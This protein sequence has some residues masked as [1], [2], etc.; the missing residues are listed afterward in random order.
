MSVASLV[1]AVVVSQNYQGYPVAPRTTGMGGAATALGRGVGNS[2]YNP[3]SIAWGDKELVGDVSGNLFAGSLTSLSSQFGL[4]TEAPRFSVQIIPSNLSLE[5]R[6]LK[7]GP[8]SLSDRWGLGVSVVAPFD[9]VLGSLVSSPDRSALVM[10]DSTERVYAISNT[11]A[12]QLTD[13]LGIGLSLVAMYRQYDAIAIVD[14]Y[15]ENAFETAMLKQSRKSISH[16]LSVGAQWRPASGFRAGL[17]VRFP[18][19]SVFGFGDDHGRATVRV[20]G[21]PELARDVVDRRVEARYEQPWR[22]NLGLAW[23]RERAFA[24]AAD[25]SVYT[26]LTYVSERD[27]DTGAT[28]QVTHLLPVVNFAVGAEFF[29]GGHGLRTGFF[30][31]HSPVPDDGAVESPRVNRYGGTF[32]FDLERKLYRTEIG[33]LLSIG[34]VRSSTSDVASGTFQRIETSG[35]EFRGILTY[36]STLKF[37]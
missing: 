12:Y 35:T 10:V 22:F 18:V 26:P 30:S 14:R 5:W 16:G 32:S 20:A 33:V 7:L 17:S 4:E 24:L 36:S 23:E 19:T 2:F 37:F 1:V 25:V 6:G 11:V 8:L 13:E 3:A 28:L 29:V 31:D 21:V 34:S 27:A 15:D 9:V